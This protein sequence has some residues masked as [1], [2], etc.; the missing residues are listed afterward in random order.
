MIS[1]ENIMEN[2]SAFLFKCW[3]TFFHSLFRPKLFLKNMLTDPQI[4][5]SSNAFL[6]IG[7]FIMYSLHRTGKEFFELFDPKTYFRIYIELSKLSIIEILIISAPISLS[8]YIILKLLRYILRLK[9]VWSKF[10]LRV[11]VTWFA[12]LHILSCIIFLFV[13]LSVIISH[14][15]YGLIK[16]PNWLILIFTYYTSYIHSYLYYLIFLI[17]LI[18]IFK[19]FFAVHRLICLKLLFAYLLIAISHYMN[20]DLFAFHDKLSSHIVKEK[21]SDDV[22]SIHIFNHSPANKIIEIDTLHR[23][24]T[25]FLH[26]DLVVHNPTIK[27]Y[28]ISTRDFWFFNFNID[29]SDSN[30]PPVGPYFKDDYQ[31]Y[32][33]VLTW[34]LTKIYNLQ[35]SPTYFIM[36]ST[37][38]IVGLSAKV[39]YTRFNQLIKV[40]KSPFL[41]YGFMPIQKYTTTQERYVELYEMDQY[42]ATKLNITFKLFGKTDFCN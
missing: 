8:V 7:V 19:K 30:D 16:L 29:S 26:M 36:P 13:V 42:I 39:P 10:F 1:I 40:K 31:D 20:L 33:F 23:N 3:Q 5:I 9:G 12:S 15:E 18:G 28:Y 41:V 37:S 6:F 22:K 35:N 38:L 17:Q 27:P 2:I 4:Y 21:E 32:P 14:E 25:V 34:H 11:T 24:D